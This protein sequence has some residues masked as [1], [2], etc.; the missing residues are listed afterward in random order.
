MISVHSASHDWPA[1]IQEDWGN[2]GR[3]HIDVTHVVPID[4]EEFAR[5][6]K[7]LEG[8]ITLDPEKNYSLAFHYKEDHTYCRGDP[9]EMSFRMAAY[10][11]M[12]DPDPKPEAESGNESGEGS[13]GG[14]ESEGEEDEKGSESGGESRSI[15]IIDG[16]GASKWEELFDEVE[17]TG[18]FTTQL[19]DHIKQTFSWKSL[20][21]HVAIQQATQVLVTYGV[22]RIQEDEDSS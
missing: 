16:Y 15:E 12:A 3:N 7:R 8:D 5:I 9:H 4:G 20:Q 17:E 10:L 1:I 21:R 22:L 2:Y 19:W 11:H 18:L 14:G 6:Q 13:G